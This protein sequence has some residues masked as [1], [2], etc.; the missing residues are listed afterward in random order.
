MGAARS[1]NQYQWNSMSMT[2]SRGAMSSLLNVMV[3]SKLVFP[4]VARSI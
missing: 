3:Q 4:A 1:L 2:H